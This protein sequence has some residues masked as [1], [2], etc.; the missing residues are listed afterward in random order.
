MNT[1]LK[2]KYTYFI[3]YIFIVLIVLHLIKF[4]IKKLKLLHEIF[5]NQNDSTIEAS[6]NAI[7]YESKGA[8]L[9]QTLLFIMKSYPQFLQM[10]ILF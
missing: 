9:E 10:V 6:G 2:F 7:A 5:V 8:K 1:L 3:F 4:L